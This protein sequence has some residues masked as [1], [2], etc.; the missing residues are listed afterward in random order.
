MTVCSVGHQRIGQHESY[1]PLK[2]NIEYMFNPEIG[3]V[4]TEYQMLY[5]FE[6][7]GSGIHIIRIRKPAG[8]NI[9]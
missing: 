1:P 2:H 7:G 5:I 9:G 6:G 3:R 4:L 8:V